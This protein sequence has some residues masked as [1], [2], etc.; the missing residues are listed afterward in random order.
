MEK[1]AEDQRQ[2]LHL[3]E[4]DLATERQMVLDLKAE[5]QK[6]KDVARVARKA[7]EAAMKA[8]YECGVQ[9]TETRL[10]EEVAAVCRDY[11]IELWGVAL[12]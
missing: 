3:T 11:S 2:K 6:S 12:D 1:Q 7:T 4:I 5:L 9:N 8:S 10:A